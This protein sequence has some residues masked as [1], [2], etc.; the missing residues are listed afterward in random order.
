MQELAVLT[1]G[2]DPEHIDATLR[3]ALL[4]CHDDPRAAVRNVADRRPELDQP[5]P[6]GEVAV[7]LRTVEESTMFHHGRRGRRTLDGLPMGQARRV[8]FPSDG[9]EAVRFE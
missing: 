5:L 9:G 1:Y 8:G 7:R 3:A 2:A 4:D 6:S